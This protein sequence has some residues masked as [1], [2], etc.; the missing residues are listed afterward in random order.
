MAE[1]QENP[2]RCCL[3]CGKEIGPWR[4]GNSNFCDKF[5]ED[6]KSCAEQY[7]QGMTPEQ[8]YKHTTENRLKPI[9][10]APTSPAD[11]RAARSRD[12]V[13]HRLCKLGE[14][15]DEHGQPLCNKVFPTDKPNKVFCEEQHQVQYNTLRAKDRRQAKERR[16]RLD[17]KKS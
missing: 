5:N 11:R 1:K 15:L 9:K 3:Y 14:Y 16:W 8:Y 13:M 7:K 17:N 10:G 4:L 2:F 6:G 12:N